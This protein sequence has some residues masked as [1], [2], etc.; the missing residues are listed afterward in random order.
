MAAIAVTTSVSAVI[1]AY[2]DDASL[3]PARNVSGRQNPAA[4]TA[5]AARTAPQN[6]DRAPQSTTP[7]QDAQNQESVHPAKE[8]AASKQT[9]GE[10]TADEEAGKQ[11]AG[12]QAASKQAAEKAARKPAKKPLPSGTATAT[13]FWDAAT[14][15]GRPMSFRTLASPYWPLGTRVKITYGGKSTIG[16]V[17]D[18]GPAEWA[19]A[20]HDIPAILDLSE[21]MMAFFTGVRSNT[22]H[23][24][25]QVLSFG[26]GRSYRSSGTGYRLAYGTGK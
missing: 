7:Q 20:Q 21:K 12:K 16:V 24:R 3:T 26:H 10:Q 14:A 18:F 1:G 25:F 17:D 13:S 5:A 9:A 8:Q 22:V 6:A 2:Q 19:V 11:A 23:A 15:S 4:P